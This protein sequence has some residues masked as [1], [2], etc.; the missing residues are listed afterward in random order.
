MGRDGLLILPPPFLR[1]QRSLP[2]CRRVLWSSFLSLFAPFQPLT[3]WE[4]FSSDRSHMADQAIA[5]PPWPCIGVRNRNT[6]PLK[7][8]RDCDED[9]P[10]APWVDYRDLCIEDSRTRL[11]PGIQAI[12]ARI[13]SVQ[14]FKPTYITKGSVMTRGRSTLG[15]DRV[16]S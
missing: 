15:G 4:N 6:I 8:Y 12:Q 5:E 1:R 9:I 13:P 7:R 11:V 3:T 16:G 2:I 10:G 14:T